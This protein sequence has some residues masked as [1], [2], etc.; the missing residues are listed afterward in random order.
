MCIQCFISNVRSL[1]I[2]KVLRRRCTFGVFGSCSLFK[3]FELQN[4]HQNLKLCKGETLFELE[5]T[6][7]IEVQIFSKIFYFFYFF[8]PS[9]KSATKM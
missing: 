1:I 2:L 9:Q 7:Y 3:Q 8:S 4:A 5:S 6:E